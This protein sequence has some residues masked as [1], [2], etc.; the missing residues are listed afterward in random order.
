MQLKC[1]APGV[2]WLLQHVAEETMKQCKLAV[3]IAVVLLLA[4]CEMQAAVKRAVLA[5]AGA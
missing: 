3:L 2:F 1:S 5:A 4:G